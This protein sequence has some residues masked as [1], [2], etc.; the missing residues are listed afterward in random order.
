MQRYNKRNGGAS[1]MDK[2]KARKLVEEYAKIVISSM[3]VNKIILYGSYARGDFRKD[4]DID[5]AVVVPRNSISKNILDDMAKL[6][7]LRRSISND[8]EPVLIIDEDDPS[9]FLESIS[10]YG[11]VVY[12]K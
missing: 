12:A 2:E 3:A 6:F 1:K 7:K 11:E 8:I 9:G 10:Q 5:V 4:S